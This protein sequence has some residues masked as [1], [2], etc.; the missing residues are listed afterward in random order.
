M[1][2]TEPYDE[3]YDDHT[4]LNI[5]RKSYNEKAQ[6]PVYNGAMIPYGKNSVLYLGGITVIGR[7]D[8]PYSDKIFQFI[9]NEM[10]W[11]MLEKVTLQLAHPQVCKLT[12]PLCE[13]LYFLP[14]LTQ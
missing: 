14:V 13:Y 8:G 5:H 3:P 1:F 4:R 11:K 6:L 9:G 2:S 7:N 10:R 12:V